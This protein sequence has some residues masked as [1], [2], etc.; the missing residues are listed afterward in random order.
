MKNSC[1]L[2]SWEHGSE[3]ATTRTKIC[4]SPASELLLP[5][6]AGNA[7]SPIVVE[8]AHANVDYSLTVQQRRGSATPPRVC[9]K[10]AG[11]KDEEGQEG[12]TEDDGHKGSSC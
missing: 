12:H 8:A 7:A 10:Q 5:A 1:T 4:T 11:N 3:I 9:Q 2:I 6:M